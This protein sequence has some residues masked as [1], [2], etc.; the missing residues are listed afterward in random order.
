MLI[1][2]VGCQNGNELDNINQ[3]KIYGFKT[4][5][6][7]TKK[8]FPIVRGDGTNNNWDRWTLE[9]FESTLGKADYEYFDLPTLQERKL[10]AEK[11]KNTEIN[12]HQVLLN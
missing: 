2:A 5:D 1:D 9:K 7:I 12:T 4:K 6:S 10:I 8:L 11:P 3:Y